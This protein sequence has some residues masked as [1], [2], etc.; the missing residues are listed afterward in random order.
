MPPAR[1]SASSACPRPPART[2][3]VLPCRGAS[4]DVPHS[5]RG[6]PDRLRNLDQHHRDGARLRRHLP[7]RTAGQDRARRSRPRHPLPGELRL[8]GCRRR[9]PGPCGAR[10]RRRQRAHP[11]APAHRARG[12]RTA[13]PRR[14]RDAAAEQGRGRGGGQEA[15]RPDL[16]EGRGHRLHA[17]PG[18]R[19]RRSHPDHDRQ[20][21]RP[22]RRPDLR[23]ARRGARPVG[24]RRTRHR[25]RKG[26]DEEGSAAADHAD[27]GPADA[28]PRRLEPVRGGRGLSRTPPDARRGGG[29]KGPGFVPWR[30][31]VAPARFP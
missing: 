10:R 2:P 14:R 8:R 7:R 18:R 21:R 31:K 30:N 24:R 22:L 1:P 12:H 6:G 27:R 16:L 29:G 5:R 28:G 25:G 20:P 3:S 4:C 26:P 15:R 17:H 19:V 23:R 11:A 13:L 9:L